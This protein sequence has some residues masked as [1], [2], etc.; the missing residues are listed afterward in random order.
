MQYEVLTPG[1][2]A[3]AA[4]VGVPGLFLAA[5][6]NKVR[7]RT[8]STRYANSTTFLTCHIQGNT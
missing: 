6:S 2:G 8:L 5:G 3:V 7:A 4:D 1:T